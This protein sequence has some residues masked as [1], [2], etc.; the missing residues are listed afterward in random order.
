MRPSITSSSVALKR[1]QN[2]IIGDRD[3]IL[4][5]QTQ[6]R[7]AASCSLLSSVWFETQRGNHHDHNNC[8]QL[9]DND[10]QVKTLQSQLQLSRII[11]E[12]EHKMLL[13]SSLP[14]LAS[15]I[16]GSTPLSSLCSSK[17]TKRRSLPGA[18]SVVVLFLALAMSTMALAN[19]DQE[20]QSGHHEPRELESMRIK[21]SSASIYDIIDQQIDWANLLRTNSNINSNSNES[22]NNNNNN[23][24]I[25]DNDHSKTS[26]LSSID[27]TVSLVRAPGA[28]DGNTNDNSDNDQQD[29][30]IARRRHQQ[31]LVD[32]NK[33]LRASLA[34]VAAA[35]IA[36]RMHPNAVRVSRSRMP[37]FSVSWA[38]SPRSIDNSNNNEQPAFSETAALLK[39]QQLLFGPNQH[40]HQYQPSQPQLLSKQTTSQHQ[41]DKLSQLEQ[42]QNQLV[43]W[44]NNNAQQQH[45]L[46]QQRQPFDSTA[47]SSNGKRHSG[48]LGYRTLMAPFQTR[49]Y[50]E[51]DL[52]TLKRVE[53]TRWNKLRG[54]WGKRSVPDKSYYASSDDHNYSM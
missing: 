9:L 28:S 41:S 29:N 45:Q 8:T 13:S 38:S 42:L 15:L 24:D 22:N 48:P 35:S 26:S 53:Q 3:S 33:Q 1:V 25:N 31:S 4:Q 16:S 23:N 43:E 46:Q 27:S 5:L 36:S 17:T 47:M 50:T 21:P 19:L 12:R 32:S 51:P 11:V 37:I 34:A 20:F 52:T 30:A 18:M 2:M 10:V 7:N 6:S 49:S 14:K 54:M 44:S 40:Q 39:E